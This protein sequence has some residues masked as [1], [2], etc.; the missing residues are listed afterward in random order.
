MNFISHTQY[1]KSIENEIKGFYVMSMG[2]EIH[3]SVRHIYPTA[4][5]PTFWSRAGNLLG[6][7]I[8]KPELEK[9]KDRFNH[10]E[11]GDKNMTCNCIET[12]YH[13]VLLPDGR[14]SL[15]CMDYGLEQ[16]L[17]N[18]FEQEYD[19][20]IPVPFSCFNLCSHCENGIEPKKLN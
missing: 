2:N 5:V 19:D 1:I 7:A 10:M 9:I 12:L 18:L 4:H 11:H 15:C 6:E 13:N 16:I 14:V 20:I 3:N 8:I 17:G